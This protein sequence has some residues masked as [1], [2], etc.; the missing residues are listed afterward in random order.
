MCVGGEGG[1]YVCVYTLLWTRSFAMEISSSSLVLVFLNVESVLC[2][3]KWSKVA[4]GQY[5]KH[6][7][8]NVDNVEQ[9]K[10]S[11]SSPPHRVFVHTRAVGRLGEVGRLW[12]GEDDW[13]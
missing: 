6:T 3:G 9:S 4:S 5:D 12:K 1:G 11:P 10:S 8:R 13:G 7:V 2:C